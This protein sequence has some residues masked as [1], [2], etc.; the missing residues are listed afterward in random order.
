MNDL[1][2]GIPINSDAGEAAIKN[3][4]EDVRALGEAA[5]ETAESMQSSSRAGIA[6][7]EAM[8]RKA[9]EVRKELQ[10]LEAA[11]QRAQRMH[12]RGGFSGAGF[13]G[14]GF[15]NSGDGFGGLRT[16]PFLASGEPAK[17]MTDAAN[18]T[19]LWGRGVT[20][21]F[22]GFGRGIDT[23]ITGAKR[24]SDAMRQAGLE[25]INMILR[26]E[27][28][29]RILPALLGPGGKGASGSG[30]LLGAA[31]SWLG[32]LF[33][34]GGGGLSGSA[35]SNSLSDTALAMTPAGMG[36]MMGFASGGEVAPDIPIMVGESGPEAFVPRSSGTILP[37]GS[38]GGETHFHF[39]V[40][41]TGADAGVEHK[42]RAGFQAAMAAAQSRAVMQALLAQQELS[43]RLPSH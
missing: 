40:D 12:G 8:R 34:G 35:V 21:A 22:T 6:G 9:Q 37:S 42:A 28:Q 15:S 26:S 5:R 20:A 3:A 43:Q 27:M 7:F 18:A 4:G 14:G 25:T 29:S 16:P 19:S 38:L 11:S 17:S 39:N 41:A 10:E 30:G 2:I 31:G 32:G 36:T 24:F 1:S 13:P 23:A 33:G